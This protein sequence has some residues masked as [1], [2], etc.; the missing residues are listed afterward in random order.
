MDSLSPRE[1]EVLGLLGH[2]ADTRDIARRL[3][4]SPHT[5][6]THINRL[7]GKLGLSSR[8][9]AASYAITHGIRSS[10]LEA[11]HD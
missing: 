11:T 8:T 9:E 4:I 3:V 5:A 2:G 10:L 1:L 6:K 7:L